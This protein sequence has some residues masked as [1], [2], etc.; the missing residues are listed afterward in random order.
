MVYEEDDN[1]RT[2]ELAPLN[3]DEDIEEETT[4]EKK[5]ENGRQ[6]RAGAASRTRAG[7]ESPSE[8]DT[9]LK[10][11]KKLRLEIES[12]K[13]E[14]E[15]LRNKNVPPPPERSESITFSPSSFLPWQAE[16]GE[17]YS[18]KTIGDAV[19]SILGRGR[20]NGGERKRCA[21]SPPNTL[22][23]RVRNH[24]YDKVDDDEEALTLVSDVDGVENDN[25]QNDQGP[26]APKGKIDPK[27][28]TSSSICDC[29]RDDDQ[30][31]Y[32]EKN[33][34]IN[35]SDDDDDEIS[36]NGD[37][38]E[39]ISCNEDEHDLNNELFSDVVKD[40]ASW[41]VGLLVLQSCSSFILKNNEQLLQNHTVIVQFLTMLVGAGGN[42]GNQ[43]S[44]R[45]IRGLAVG[46]LN[47]DTRL[48]FL[49]REA[50]MALCLSTMLGFAGL[51]RAA[52]FNIPLAETV[53]IT[54]SL[55]MIVIISIFLG[56]LLPLGMKMVGIDPAHSSTTIQVVMDILGVTITCF[57]SS[58]ILGTSIKGK[59]SSLS[60]G[61][62]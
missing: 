15:K 24:N 51:L 42:A 20:S 23:H 49:K 1:E 38:V 36:E 56:A 62:K 48:P 35:S 11:N 28:K 55:Y 6:A 3:L 13:R 17:N 60:S 47:N 46:S 34:D 22:H 37:F 4:T 9:L 19:G 30:R 43:A 58:L 21:P 18:F 5:I 45:V 44:V 39:P 29:I 50:M 8:P 25:R 61:E 57:M 53:A 59:I 27:A 41:L 31:E 10:E 14:M 7:S 40:R 16:D 32:Y 26:R 2:T 52:V 12:L 54:A 33:S